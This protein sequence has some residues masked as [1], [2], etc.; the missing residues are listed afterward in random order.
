MKGRMCWEAS[1][2][3]FLAKKETKEEMIPFSLWSLLCLCVT[4]G[5]CC[6]HPLKVRKGSL[7]VEPTTESGRM[8]REGTW[9]HGYVGELLSQPHLLSVISKRTAV[10]VNESLD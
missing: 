3:V 6:H 4:L 9:A 7:R 10:L 8:E 2:K 1:G 5:N